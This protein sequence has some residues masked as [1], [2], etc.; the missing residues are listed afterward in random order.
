MFNYREDTKNRELISKLLPSGIN[1]SGLQKIL[2]QNIIKTN[3]SFFFNKKINED[4]ILLYTNFLKT[5]FYTNEAG[6]IIEGRKYLFDLILAL[7]YEEAISIEEV[8]N[9]LGT[10]TDS[11][12]LAAIEIFEKMV[13]LELGLFSIDLTGAASISTKY[14]KKIYITDNIP[15]L[16]YGEKYRLTYK[17]ADNILDELIIIQNSALTEESLVIG[18]LTTLDALDFSLDGISGT[19]P[20]PLSSI[21]RINRYQANI[22]NENI[23]KFC[24][25]LNYNIETIEATKY[26]D[27]T[28]V[29]KYLA[30][31]SYSGNT[32]GSYKKMKSDGTI[33]TKYFTNLAGISYY[34]E[35]NLMFTNEVDYLKQNNFLKTF[36]TFI[37]DRTINY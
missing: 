3:M 11:E 32:R 34:D 2:K 28:L 12:V 36:W 10:E 19:S 24:F 35:L 25:F 29:K 18:D 4:N 16:Y 9:I 1:N 23:S 31:Q 22:E 17:N 37:L 26:Y 20:S 8:F 15:T 14:F 13:I 27:E 5:D 7:L 21:T 6:E 33:E 30:I